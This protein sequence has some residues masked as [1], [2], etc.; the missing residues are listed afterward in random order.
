MTLGGHPNGLS[1]P[2]LIWASRLLG[3]LSPGQAQVY[4]PYIR[5]KAVYAEVS[6]MGTSSSKAEATLWAQGQGARQLS[7]QL[8]FRLQVG[9]AHTSRPTSPGWGR[10]APSQPL[11]WH[12]GHFSFSFL[13]MPVMVPPVPADATSMSSLPDRGEGMSGSASSGR[14][15]RPPLFFFF[16]HLYWSIIALQWCVSFCSALHS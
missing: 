3:P 14:S 1:H 8:Q 13:A 16:E 9:N 7:L 6:E 10:V 2:Q 12:P 4:P 11:T 15:G 5:C